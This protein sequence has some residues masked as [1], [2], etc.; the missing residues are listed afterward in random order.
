M[1]GKKEVYRIKKGQSRR[2][3]DLIKIDGGSFWD[4]WTIS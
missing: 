4:Y 2:A 1:Y 3:F